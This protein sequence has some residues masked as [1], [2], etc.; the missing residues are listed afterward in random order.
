MINHDFQIPIERGM[1]NRSKIKIPSKGY[2]E[3]QTRVKKGVKGES[4]RDH[5]RTSLNCLIKPLTADICIGIVKLPPE[6]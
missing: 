2:T 1:V 5:S 3:N 4:N 6:V